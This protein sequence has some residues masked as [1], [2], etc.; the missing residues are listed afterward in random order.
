MCPPDW[1]RLISPAFSMVCFNGSTIW[2]VKTAKYKHC[3]EYHSKVRVCCHFN[4]QRVFPHHCAIVITVILKRLPIMSR[5]ALY[6]GSVVLFSSPQC[7]YWPRARQ[8]VAAVRSWC[9]PFTTCKTSRVTQLFRFRWIPYSFRR[10]VILDGVFSW[11]Y[12]VLV[13]YFRIGYVES[14]I[15]WISK[16]F[17]FKHQLSS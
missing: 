13:W 6:V 1:S 8:W 2:F 15:K 17:K 5:E 7:P 16:H 14:V 4:L 9:A 10:L 12:S 11:F 3:F